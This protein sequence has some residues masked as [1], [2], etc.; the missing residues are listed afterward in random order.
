MSH[1]ESAAAQKFIIAQGNSTTQ[2][3][4]IA[5]CVEDYVREN[6]GESPTNEAGMANA[7]WVVI[8]YGD[9]WV[10]IFPA[11]NPDSTTTSKNCGA[12]P[13]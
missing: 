2:V 8:D 7:E 9:I 1:I 12:T 11:R 4:S 5:E 6:G 10:H 13:R 3:G